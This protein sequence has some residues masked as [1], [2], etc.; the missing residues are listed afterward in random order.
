MKPLQ[1]SPAT[2]VRAVAIGRCRILKLARLAGEAFSFI[3]SLDLVRLDLD[4]KPP[5]EKEFGPNDDPHDKNMAIDEDKSRPWPDPEKLDA[6]WKK[7][8]K[9]VY[10]RRP[11]FHWRGTDP[12]IS[13][14]KC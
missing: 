6:W 8:G 12:G 1:R 4:R 13:A 7:N 5:D 2:R 3:T 14:S 9:P 11:I 10:A